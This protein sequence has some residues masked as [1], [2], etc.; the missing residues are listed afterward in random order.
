[1]QEA[2]YLSK[3]EE[4][5]QAKIIRE[6]NDQKKRHMNFKVEQENRMKNQI[7]TQQKHI[8]RMKIDEERSRKMVG[9]RKQHD[10]KVN[11]E[12]NMRL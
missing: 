3:R 5:K 9:V 7:I 6:Q 10:E 11:S 2:I 12:D 4:A 8:A 1:V